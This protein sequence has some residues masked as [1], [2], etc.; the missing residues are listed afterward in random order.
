MSTFCKEIEVRW[1]DVD[2]NQHLRHSAYADF[3]THI[4]VEW[5][6][7]LGFPAQRFAKLG[8]GPVL[9]KEETEYLREVPPGDRV[10]VDLQLEAASADMG[11]WR[12][13]QHIY[14][15]D[16]VL[17]AR[18]RVSGGWLNLRERKLMPPPAELAVLLAQLEH[19]E[20]FEEIA[21]SR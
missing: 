13:L 17:A 19:A 16:G 1:A 7:S 6:S 8:F 14:R 9:Q 2:A 20:G 11:R 21:S 12:F 15:S 10:R 3:A 5:L 18:H 4:R